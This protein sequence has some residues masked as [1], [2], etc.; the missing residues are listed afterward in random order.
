MK[1]IFRDKTVA[2]S[3]L[4]TASL[5]VAPLDVRAQ[6]LATDDAPA[7]SMESIAA[8]V[9]SVETAETPELVLPA[10]SEIVV[11]TTETA[12]ADAET[13]ESAAETPFVAPISYDAYCRLVAGNARYVK[14][15]S[16]A[17]NE[18]PAVPLAANANDKTGPIATLVYA[19]DMP[20]RPDVLT[21]TT[22]NDVYLSSLAAGVVSSDDLP[23]I[24]YGVLNLQ[25]PLLV[26][27][28][29]FP[30]RDVANI[31]R[32]YDSL[33]KRAQAE[34]D[35]LAKSA[36][37]GA[38]QKT[39]AKN[40][41][42]YNLVGPA[43][44]RAREAYP[45]LKGAELANV[46]SEA[47]VWQSLETILIKSVVVQDLIRA[48]KLDVIG[49]IADDATGQIYWLGRH[50]T[51]DEFLKPASEETI[52]NARRLETAATLDAAQ[53]ETAE[54]VLPEP[55]GDAQIQEYAEL[56]ESNGY[57]V[58]PIATYYSVPV[59]YAPSWELFAPR[60]WTYRPGYGV[61][62]PPFTP[63]PYYDPW[64]PPGVVAPQTR[65]AFWSGGAS[66]YIGFNYGDV[67]RYVGPEFRPLNPHWATEIYLH[68]TFTALD[69]IYISLFGDARP[70][71]PPPPP[72][73]LPPRGPRPGYR[74]GHFP[75][76]FV[77]PGADAPWRPHRPGGAPAP[78]RP[79]PG[80][81]PG[82][83]GPGL[84]PPGYRPGALGPGL[85]PPGYR[86]GAPGARPDPFRPG[87]VRPENPRPGTVRPGIVRPDN[88]RPGIVRPDNPRPG[89]VRPDAP[90][91]ENPGRPGI[92]RPEN[93]GANRPGIGRPENPGANRPGISRPENPG[94]NRPGVGRPE[95]PGT[96][97]PGIG[98]PENPGANRPGVG[99]PENPGANRP[100]I[101][102]PEN[103]GANRPGI[104]RPNN[105]G[106]NRPGAGA[107][108]NPGANRPNPG[109][110][111]GDR[112]GR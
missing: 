58:D 104:G 34:A 19:A 54:F 4:L 43:I 37:R 69:S 93:P 82:A 47:L 46:V 49:A 84:T 45:D 51:Q 55:L 28:G 21:Q 53:A 110:P 2:L 38:S 62:A 99:R 106:A 112:P 86:P 109:R 87:G 22:E 92:G 23:A 41:Q 50:P 111:G 32:Q 11:A 76:G 68:P 40:L 3:V 29:H 70:P 39:V 73:P 64:A 103:P 97:R 9:E 85:T 101:G 98:R 102:R 100:G 14:K 16:T 94:A 48:D 7:I 8:D 17:A 15:S 10:E 63:W 80:Y 20:T 25:T 27:V 33:A 60:A 67:Y 1:R 71:L 5:A 66:F 6:T 75:P 36:N 96:N 30:S 95:N 31:V 77:S 88:P 44:A 89:I 79:R 105:P 13:A 12:S 18:L 107:R 24:E 81:V 35:R 61:W 78:G 59:Y 90:R 72:K 57:Y 91:P 83:L 74:P 56:Y 65:L 26:V 42:T 52:A 108:P